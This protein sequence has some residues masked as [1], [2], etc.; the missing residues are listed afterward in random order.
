L[1]ARLEEDGAEAVRDPPQ[2][3][4]VDGRL[5]D[6][7]VEVLRRD[8]GPE[9]RSPGVANHDRLEPS[10]VDRVGDLAECRGGAYHRTP[11]GATWKVT[12]TPASK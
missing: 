11:L 8:A 4:E 2:L 5:A 12:E 6:H 7:E 10:H 3:A 1:T 9:E